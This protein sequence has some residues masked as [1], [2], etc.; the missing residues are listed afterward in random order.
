MIEFYTEIFS[1]GK[2]KLIIKFSDSEKII[3]D[4]YNFSVEG[5]ASDMGV[6]FAKYVYD[7][8]YSENYTSLRQHIEILDGKGEKRIIAIGSKFSAFW[9]RK[10]HKC[11]I[12]LVWEGEKSLEWLEFEK[13]FD[14]YFNL[15]AFL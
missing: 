9:A 10:D 14:R 4:G 13:G 8:F 6:R 1:R 5:S 12:G 7:Y 3:M 2:K 15:R 11:D